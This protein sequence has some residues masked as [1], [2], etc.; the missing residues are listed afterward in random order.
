MK[1]GDA[2]QKNVNES[3]KIGV[4]FSAIQLSRAAIP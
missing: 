2:T 4:T 1:N 3:L